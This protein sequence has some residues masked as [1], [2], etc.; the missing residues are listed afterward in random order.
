MR[1]TLVALMIGGALLTPLRAQPAPTFN[2]FYCYKSRSLGSNPTILV[3]LL[4]RFEF[5]GSW[6]PSARDSVA[7][8]RAG[9]SIVRAFNVGVLRAR[10]DTAGL[11][12]LL[13]SDALVAYPVVDSTNAEVATQVIFG[14]PLVDQD[15]AAIVRLGARALERHLGHIV[16]AILPDS[17]IPALKA[18]PGVSIV[19]AHPVACGEW[20]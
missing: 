4:L 10:L 20:Y 6:R 9:G 17:A 12:Q 3:D 14:R 18:V 19:Q 15:T 5:D 7:V 1:P 13:T 11:R 8:T 16:N 2:Q